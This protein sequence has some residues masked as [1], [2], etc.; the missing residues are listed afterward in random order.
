MGQLPDA[1]RPAAFYCWHGQPV[2]R[3]KEFEMGEAR[4]VMDRITK[5]AVSKDW[6]TLASLYAPDAVAVDPIAGQ[7]TGSGIVDLFK[8]FIEPFPED[9]NFEPLAAHEA[10]NV[11]I[12]EGYIVGTNTGPLALPSGETISA[13]GKSVRIRSCDV[14]T[15]KDG[16]AVSHHFYYDQ[17]ELLSQLGLAPETPAG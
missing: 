14:L 4:E 12:D 1:R 5:A 3:R 6:E 2:N 17:M 9:I 10:G 11:A 13:T 7:L 16:V 8:E 15:V